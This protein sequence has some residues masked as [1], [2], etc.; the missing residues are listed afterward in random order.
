MEFEHV[1]DKDIDEAKQG[2]ALNSPKNKNSTKRMYIESYGCQ[3]NFS[4]S[5]IVGSILKKEGFTTTNNLTKTCL[6]NFWRS[7]PLPG[8]LDLLQKS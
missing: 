1:I 4:D 6:L 7:I 5:E 3:M 8:I 2:E